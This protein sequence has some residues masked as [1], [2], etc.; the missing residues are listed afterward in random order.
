MAVKNTKRREEILTAAYRMLGE[1]QYDQVSLSDIAKAVGINKSLLQHYYTQK[2][3]IVNTMLGEL[4]ETSSAYMGTLSFQND[5]LFQ[6]ISDFNMLFFKGVAG[7]YT[8]RQFILSSVRQAE[9]LDAWVDTICNWLR[10]YCGE[11]TFT[12]R[13]LKT[14][15]IFAMGGTMHLFIHQDELDIDYRRFCSVHIR[16]ILSLLNYDPARIEAI[17]AET[18]RRID[19]IDVGAFLKYCEANIAWLTL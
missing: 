7:D 14:A 12:F 13:Q 9:C 10:R 18:D 1:K 16:A 17:S 19:Q 4:L 15:I 5:D 3:E 11:A 8:L 6:G 2:I